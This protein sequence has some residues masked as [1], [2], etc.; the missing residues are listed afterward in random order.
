[1]LRLG[2]LSPVLLTA[3]LLGSAPVTAGAATYPP[4][5]SQDIGTLSE[6]TVREGA[7][8]V[9]SG[10]GFVPGALLQLSYDGR[11]VRQISADSRG[12]FTLSQQL[13][14]VGDHVLAVTG[15]GPGNRQRIVY[16]PVKVVALT[17]ASPTALTAAPAE[18]P[19]RKST[20]TLLA[21][22]GGLGVVVLGAFVRLALRARRVRGRVPA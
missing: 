9:M 3:V 4:G 17:A 16:D 10:D 15:P 22:V 21:L 5:P 18:S 14:D 6:Q 19:A 13:T 12:E 11:P 2:W 8:V 1:M 20:D 7:V